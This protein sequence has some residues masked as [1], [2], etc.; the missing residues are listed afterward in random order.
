MVNNIP[1]VF[2]KKTHFRY[3]VHKSPHRFLFLQL[4]PDYALAYN[5]LDTF[6]YYPATYILLNILEMQEWR[7]EFVCNKWYNII[8]YISH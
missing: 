6:Q 7:K 3:R 8:E 2:F 1:T 4:I 5:T